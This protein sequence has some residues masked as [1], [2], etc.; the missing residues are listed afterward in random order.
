MEIWNET[1]RCLSTQTPQRLARNHGKGE[2]GWGSWKS[3]ETS[4]LK[5]DNTDGAVLW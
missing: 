3:L 5:Q 2:R 1:V 4:D